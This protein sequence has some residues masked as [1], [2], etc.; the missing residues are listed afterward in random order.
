MGRHDWRV[1]YSPHPFTLRRQLVELCFDAHGAALRSQLAAVLREL[2][3]A[4]WGR[5]YDAELGMLLDV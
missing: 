5:R 1:V 3:Y 2:G 4:Y